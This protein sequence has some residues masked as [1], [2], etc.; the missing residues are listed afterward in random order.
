[1]VSC[2]QQVR[3]QPDL[4][5]YVEE[6][7]LKPIKNGQTIVFHPSHSVQAFVDFCNYI[8]KRLTLYSSEFGYEYPFIVTDIKNNRPEGEIHLRTPQEKWDGFLDEQGVFT[9][10][11]KGEVSGFYLNGYAHGLHQTNTMKNGL[12][13]SASYTFDNGVAIGPFVVKNKE[14]YHYGIVSDEKYEEEY[15]LYANDYPV[16]KKMGLFPAY[17][18]FIT[19]GH[20]RKLAQKYIRP[21]VALEHKR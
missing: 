7:F 11:R 9:G 5:P 8:P 13:T 14:T 2:V 20:R 1:M 4:T 10:W 18:S 15:M 16:F 12:K 21:S 19:Q 3:I 6:A 17:A